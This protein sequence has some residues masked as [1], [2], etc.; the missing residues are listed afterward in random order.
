MLSANKQRC[1]RLEHLAPLIFLSDE[2]E[3]TVV[4]DDRDVELRFR[5]SAS[6]PVRIL[7]F[8]IQ[9][10]LHT[11]GDNFRHLS[12][13]VYIG[14]RGYLVTVMVSE[15]SVNE[16]YLVIAYTKLA[17]CLTFSLIRVRYGMV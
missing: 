17:L 8:E 11:A 5:V 14:A 2:F 10:F 15:L 7:Q 4:S 16:T 12:R 1:K 9:F 13:M 3:I 6:M